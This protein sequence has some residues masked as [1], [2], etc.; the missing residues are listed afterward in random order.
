[1]MLMPVLGISIYD[2]WRRESR[3]T[4]KTIGLQEIHRWLGWRDITANKEQRRIHAVL[5]T[6]TN[7]CCNQ[8]K[9]HL[10]TASTSPSKTKPHELF[11]G[12]RHW[13]R[14]QWQPYMAYELITTLKLLGVFQILLLICRSTLLSAVMLMDWCR[15]GVLKCFKPHFSARSLI[16]CG[17]GQ[18]R[19]CPLR[20]I[21]C[22]HH[23][24]I[25]RTLAASHGD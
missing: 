16:R 13:L 20:D 5:R 3:L 7:T 23:H 21:R 1:M 14:G 9:W 12:P 18:S 19:S 24:Q 8:F 10:C 6:E 2:N 11:N 25:Y 17:N 22:L 4:R 15:K